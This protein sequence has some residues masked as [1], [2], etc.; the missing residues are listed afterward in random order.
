MSHLA[1]CASKPLTG[2]SETQIT[3]P[4]RIYTTLNSFNCPARTNP[5]ATVPYMQIR[6]CL[7]N[8]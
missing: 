3:L 4:V 5:M 8:H 1:S 7:Q 6:K 2:I